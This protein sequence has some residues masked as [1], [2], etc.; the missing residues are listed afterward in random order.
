MEHFKIQT[1][2]HSRAQ[3]TKTIYWVHK[4][5]KQKA[6]ELQGVQKNPTETLKTRRQYSHESKSIKASKTSVSESLVCS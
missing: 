1:E 4:E 6:L 5:G 2:I 3:R